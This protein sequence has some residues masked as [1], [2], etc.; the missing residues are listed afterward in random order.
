[1]RTTNHKPNACVLFKK[2][3]D[4]K[5]LFTLYIGVNKNFTPIYFLI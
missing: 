1:M 4:K 2:N 3:T 5:T